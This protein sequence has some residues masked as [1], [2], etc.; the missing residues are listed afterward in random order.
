MAE[1]SNW[2]TRKHNQRGFSLIEMLIV[3]TILLIMV[4]MGSMVMMPMLQQSH[5]ANAY[6]TTLATMRLGRQVAIAKRTVVS[7][8][9]SNAAIP[10]T[11]TVKDTNPT[12]PTTI[13]TV[14]L[15]NDVS[16]DAEPTLPNTVA[17][18]PDN[19]GTGA[20]AISFDMG[21]APG[22]PNVVYFYPDGSAQDIANNINN[23]VV[24]IARPGVVMSSKAIT[25]WGATGRLRGWTLITVGATK[26]WIQQ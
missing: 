15:P 24:Y 6:N 9:L 23:G 7:V 5:V 2:M 16:F 10:N 12:N 25:L 20:P 13:E 17:T 18:T 19:F 4:W 1:E 22:V 3:I 21:V 14:Q 11:I 8:T 26:T